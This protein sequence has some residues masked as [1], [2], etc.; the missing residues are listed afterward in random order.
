[1]TELEKHHDPVFDSWV[2]KGQQVK[3]FCLEHIVSELLCFHLK[4]FHSQALVDGFCL[5]YDVSLLNAYG[6]SC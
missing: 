4:S 3:C 2:N 5:L 6:C 1:M